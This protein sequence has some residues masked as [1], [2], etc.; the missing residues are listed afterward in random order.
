MDSEAYLRRIAYEGDRDPTFEVL[1]GLHLAHVR[2]VAFENSSVLRGE[3]IVLEARRLVAKIVGAG[4]G[5]FCFELNGA[6]AALLRAL[7]FAVELMPGQFWSD[8]GLGQAFEH[9]CLRVTLDDGPFL[10]DVGAGFSFV[11]PLRLVVDLEQTDP[12]GRF[13]I[14]RPTADET[15]LE[16]EWLH[17]D[18]VW[19]PHYRFEP[20]AVQ[21]A[22]FAATCDWLRTSP[23]SAFTRGWRCARALPN[24]YATLDGRRL[25]V[26]TAGSR[27]VIELEDDTALARALETWFGIA[28]NER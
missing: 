26:S 6:F 8:T 20:R 15:V 19:R 13:R 9:L 22:D 2:A 14:V 4:R 24:G 12:N 18:G 28:E 1:R 10:V 11:E 25:I 17:R 7:G 16:V 3:A 27:E 21:L 5:G 23:E